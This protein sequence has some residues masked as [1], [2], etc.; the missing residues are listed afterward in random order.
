MRV[1]AITPDSR[2]ID[3]ASFVAHGVELVAMSDVGH[4]TMMEDPDTVNG[5]LSNTID[6]LTKPDMQT[7]A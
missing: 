1:V 5:H 4:F 6:Q 2:P 3:R 7:S